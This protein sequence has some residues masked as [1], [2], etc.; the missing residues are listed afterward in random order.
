[1]GRHAVRTALDFD[2]VDRVVVADRDGGRATAFAEECGDKATAAQLDIEDG[3]ALRALLEDADA[4]LNTVGPFYRFGEPVLRAAIDTGT[5]YFDICDD[6]EP[7]LAMLSLD[8]E[9][10]T[11]GVTAVVGI[12][13]SPGISNMLA[14]KAMAGLDEVASIVTGWGLEGTGDEAIA[15]GGEP[16][17]ALVHWLH[18][19]SGTIRIL[20]G[21]APVDVS[22]VE[23]V[24]VDFPGIGASSAWTVGHPEAVT[25]PRGRP[26]VRESYNVMVAP[27]W[28]IGVVRSIA[29]EIDTGRMTVEQ[30]AALMT[31]PAPDGA[32][33]EAEPEGQPR[34]PPL[35]AVATGR[36]DGEPCTVGA[37]VLSGPAGGMGGVT[38]IPLALALRLLADG[39]IGRQGVSAPEE[40]ID[41]DAFFDALA[42]YCEP[43]KTG[44]G[45]LV[46]VGTS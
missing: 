33:H 18:Q 42:P 15:P 2:F 17:A 43:P 3:A 38:G 31:G 12:G 22:P 28:L 16:S 35:F 8:G 13:A 14:A 24:T 4:V 34:L 10:R 41:P 36:K 5:H 1:M 27:R 6:W 20:R 40:A 39:K 23:E 37:T 45:D 46:H 44:V 7:T 26:Y 32:S 30:G 21:G 19:C 25:L 29:A 11:A 9:A